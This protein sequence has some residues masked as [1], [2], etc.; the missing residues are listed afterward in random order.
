MTDFY[1]LLGVGI[2]CLF[3]GP[4]GML[5]PSSDI[6]ILGRLALPLGPICIIGA[7]ILYFQPYWLSVYALLVWLLILAAILFGIAQSRYDDGEDPLPN[8]FV[9]SFLAGLAFAGV[10]FTIASYT[11]KTQNVRYSIIR[12]ARQIKKAQQEQ[13]ELD[14]Q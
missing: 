1:I 14:R 7:V 5:W 2:A 6:K 4:I 8:D 13:H 9:I 12:Y 11:P 10:L 3:L